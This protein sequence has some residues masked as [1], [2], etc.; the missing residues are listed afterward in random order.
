MRKQPIL[1]SAAITACFMAIIVATLAGN[2]H[3]ALAWVGGASLGITLFHAHF[4]FLTGHEYDDFL[5]LAIANRKAA[6]EGIT[7][8][9]GFV[10]HSIYSAYKR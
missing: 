3:V 4:K 8:E 2:W 7:A 10:R 9:K 6:N 1:R 5:E